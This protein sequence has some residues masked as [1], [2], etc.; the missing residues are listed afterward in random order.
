MESSPAPW[1]SALRHSHDR[2]RTA[3][4]PLSVDQ[5]EQRSYASEW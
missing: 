2:L 3:V 4:E 1:I 5:L